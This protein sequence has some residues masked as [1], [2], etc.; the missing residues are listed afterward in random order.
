MTFLTITPL[1]LGATTYFYHHS[2]V[3]ADLELYTNGI[4]QFL[5]FIYVAVE[6]CS[7]VCSFSLPILIPPGGYNTICYCVFKLSTLIKE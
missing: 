4:L 2:L 5:R 7:V 6:V 1:P 3:L